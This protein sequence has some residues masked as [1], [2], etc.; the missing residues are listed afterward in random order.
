MLEYTYNSVMQE[1]K[2]EIASG[3]RDNDDDF[4]LV[5]SAG[6]QQSLS[7]AGKR[8]LLVG[9][10]PKVRI[11][12][13]PTREQR[14]LVEVR[15]RHEGIMIA[16]GNALPLP[17]TEWFALLTCRGICPLNKEH[18]ERHSECWRVVERAITGG[19]DHVLR[20]PMDITLCDSAKM[21]GVDIRLCID[22]KRVS[23]ITTIMEYAMPLVDDLMTNMEAYLW[24]CSLHVA[25]RFWAVMMPERARK[26]SAFVCALGHFEWR[27]M[28]FGLTNAPMIYQRMTACDRG[29][30]EASFPI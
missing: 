26:V 7:F 20:Q 16:S 30:N 14:N 17:H 25:S 3:N 4:A 29:F 11:L 2:A 23:T 6:L 12:S 5:G 8:V 22:Y 1:I 19:I 18:G 28:P 24:F 10:H 9:T 13:C 27:R 21:N 15:K